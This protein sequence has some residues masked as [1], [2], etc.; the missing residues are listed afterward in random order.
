MMPLCVGLFLLEISC[1]RRTSHT[2]VHSFALFMLINRLA[3]LAASCSV[4]S[5]KKG[6]TFR[7]LQRSHEHLSTWW[8]TPVLSGTRRT[9]ALVCMWS[10]FSGQWLI[11]G[12]SR[13]LLLLQPLMKSA[14][15]LFDWCYS[16]VE[17]PAGSVCFLLSLAA[18]QKNSIKGRFRH[19]P[20]ISNRDQDVCRSISSTSAVLQAQHHSVR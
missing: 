6:Y 4:R 5:M 16:D 13:R 17:M 14:S 20:S 9:P 19:F 10:A 15:F 3:C 2:L 12:W 8:K 1:S 11:T 7:G 18:S